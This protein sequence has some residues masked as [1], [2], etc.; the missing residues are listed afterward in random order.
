MTA[1]TLNDMVSEFMA[2][3]GQVTQC[4][5]RVARAPVGEPVVEEAAQPVPSIGRVRAQQARDAKA[6]AKRRAQLAMERLTAPD[7]PAVVAVVDVTKLARP[8]RMAKG[9]TAPVVNVVSKPMGDTA[10]VT[11]FEAR[12]AY[13]LNSGKQAV[14]VRTWHAV[15]QETADLLEYVQKANGRFIARFL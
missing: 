8:V 2:R 14:Q 7:A 1:Q 5:K 4:P 9:P 6:L 12:T 13:V 3:G 10:I 15:D 11:T